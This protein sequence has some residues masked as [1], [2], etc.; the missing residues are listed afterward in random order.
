MRALLHYTAGPRLRD[1]LDE[2]GGDGLEL[3]WSPEG[4]RDA[5]FAALATTDALLHVLEP[6]TAEVI[7]AAP[8]LRFIQ[9]LGVGVNTI[10]LDAARARGVMVANM[11]GANAAAVA[12]MTVALLLAVL[13][14]VP[15]FDR[16]TREGSGLAAGSGGPRRARRGGGQDRRPRRLRRHRPAGRGDRDG[17]GRHR[18]PPSANPVGSRLA[19]ARRAARGGRRRVAPRPAH[20]RDEAAARRPSHRPAEAD[21]RARQHQPRRGA[22]PGRPD[23][24]ADATGAWPAPAST[25]SPPSRSTPP[26]RLLALPNVVVSPHVAWLTTDTLER[27]V[28][29]A[30]EN[31]RRL[32]QGDEPLQRVC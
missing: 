32:M 17:D 2:L 24:G 12:E 25:S 30:V 28:R 14:R 19:P 22:R 29:L 21:G 9:K 6:I 16:E 13:R 5:L 18:R 4:D 27:C 8:R 1:L 31:C 15:A 7:D 11:P 26:I 20:R 3:A 10:D 23:R